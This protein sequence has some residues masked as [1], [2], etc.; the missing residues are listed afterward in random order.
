LEKELSFVEIL[1][2]A[3]KM[4]IE[5]VKLLL[6][7]RPNLLH[8]KSEG[9]NRT[10]LWEAVNSKKL[11]LVKYLISLGADVNIPGRYRNKNLLL[12][13]P[14]CIAIQKKQLQMTQLLIDNG[15]EMDIY[16]ASYLGLNDIVTSHIQDLGHQ[17]SCKYGLLFLWSLKSRIYRIHHRVMLLWLPKLPKCWF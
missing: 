4:D 6:Q 14:Y 7:E 2:E 15:H 1:K 12:L 8:Q 3:T 16:S 5:E 11:D 13:K 10:L 17:G 9:H